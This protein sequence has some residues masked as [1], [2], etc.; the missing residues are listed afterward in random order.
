MFKLSQRIDCTLLCQRL[1]LPPDRCE[2]HI[3]KCSSTRD[4]YLSIPQRLEIDWRKY[5]LKLKKAIYGLKQAPLAW[6]NCLKYWLQSVGFSACKL[7]PCVFYQ[8][9]PEA[10]WIYV[11]V[12]NIAIFGT[13]IQLFTEKINRVFNTKDIGPSDLLLGVKIQQQ[14]DYIILDQQHFVNSLLDLYS[15]QHCKAV[16]TPLVPNEYL[17][18][19]TNDK[20]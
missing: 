12:D 8:K 10:L 6:Y 5:C 13:N 4:I 18:P 9:E 16:N 3:L 15:M 14:D 2:E 20:R 19:A 1:G 7:D 11:H 17:S